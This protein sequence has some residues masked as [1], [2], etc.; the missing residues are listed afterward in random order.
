M[1]K[2]LALVLSNIIILSFNSYVWEK[3]FVTE[4]FDPSE[5]RRDKYGALIKR[6]DYG[7]RYS[8]HGWGIDLVVPEAQGGDHDLS[9]LRPLQ[10]DNLRRRRE[11]ATTIR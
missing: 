6:N 5:I 4:G 9:N 8:V 3:A 1:T 10:W 2:I 11:E 7:N